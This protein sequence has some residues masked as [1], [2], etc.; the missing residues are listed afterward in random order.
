MEIPMVKKSSEQ[1]APS[2]E[3]ENWAVMKTWTFAVLYQRE[4]RKVVLM[5]RHFGKSFGT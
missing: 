2:V 1:G 4:K 3:K 5:I